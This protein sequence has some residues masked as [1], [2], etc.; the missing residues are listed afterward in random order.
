M[1][2]LGLGS[3]VGDRLAHLRKALQAIQKIPG[4][5]VEQVSPVYLSD[6]LLPD[7]APPE[8]DMPHLNLALRCHT[9]LEP[10]ALLKELKNIEWSI[11]RKPEVRHW[12]P[13]IIDIDILAWGELVLQSEIFTVPHLNLQ[14]RPFAL[15]PLA[16]V[17]P[18]WT[19]PLPGPNQG[20][21]AAQ[22]AEK[23]GSRFTGEAPL[24]TQQIY[25]RVDTPR[26][27]GVVNVTPDS[28][29]DGGQF[30][31]ADHALAHAL[32]L[33]NSGAEIIDI[34]AESTAP[35]A[36]PLEVATEWARLEPILLALKNA[37]ESFLIPPKISVDTRHTEV[38]AKALAMGV[39]WINDV[40]GLQ[41]PAM[42]EIVLHSNAD[43]V[44]MH[45]MSIP[46]SRDVVLPRDQDVV[47]LVYEWGA[48][49][50]ESLERRGIPRERMIFDP[51]VGFGKVPEH[52]LM[53]V[54]EAETFKQLGVRLLIGHSRKSFLSLFTGH[55]A[56]ERDV[57]TIA[58]SFYL[59][60]H[61]VDYLRVHEVEMSAR[62]LRVA[63]AL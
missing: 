34:G 26:L 21:T 23:W 24:R 60:K 22:I 20:K 28:F 29:S 62:T 12:G 53:L 38:A 44:V 11:G 33:V 18:L 63:A 30:V 35:K 59:A 55:P 61:Q 17:A 45:H 14:D 50:L 7:N 37:R 5:M 42:Q 8:W 49:Q 16:D 1:V 25:Q 41:D 47:E 48:K 2:V 54:K 6:A 31:S 32:L 9:T 15:W 10:L 27:V 3:N 58:M 13:R 57:E 56:A 36:A 40:T 39:D 46:A 43:C 4:V 52:S 19:F 51:G